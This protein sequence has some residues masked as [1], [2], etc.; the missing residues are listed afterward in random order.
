MREDDPLG[1]SGRAGGEDHRRRGVESLTPEPRQQAPERRQ[2]RQERRRRGPRLVDGPDLLGQVLQDDQIPPGTDRDLLQH[3]LRGDG[4]RDL[5]LRDRRIDRFLIGRIVEVHRHPAPERQGD[6]GHRAGAGRR[7]E[8]A[9]VPPFADD[10]LQGPP[11]RQ[12]LEQ[13]L[14]VRER[15]AGAVGEGRGAAARPLPS[16]RRPV[17]ATSRLR[18]TE[19]A[20]ESSPDRSRRRPASRQCAQSSDRPSRLGSKS[21][22]RIAC[23]PI[24]RRRF[25]HTPSARPQQWRPPDL[26]PDRSG[27]NRPRPFRTANRP[28][29]RASCRSRHRRPSTILTDPGGTLTTRSIPSMILSREYSSRQGMD[30]A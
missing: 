17:P 3:P 5:R 16:P 21:T 12:C 2:W 27:S 24:P 20:F 8:D 25:D 9:D 19:R 7:Q 29:G 18:A 30:A 6:V 13:R 22:P 26:F 28:A 11:Q 10:P 15:R 14:A 1:L 4:V 23:K